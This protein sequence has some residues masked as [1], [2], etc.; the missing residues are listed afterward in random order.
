MYFIDHVLA[1]T[2]GFS[3]SDDY[4]RMLENIVYI[5]LR[6]RQFSVYYHRDKKECDFII[7]EGNHIIEAIQVSQTLSNSATKQRETDGLLEAMETYSLREGYILTENEEGEERIHS[8]GHEYLIHI[9]PLWR[10]LLIQPSNEKMHK[11]F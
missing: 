6:R 5:E 8:N 9:M 2:L 7:Q 11:N 1:K 10:W 3:F 4:G